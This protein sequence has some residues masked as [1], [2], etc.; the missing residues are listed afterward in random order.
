MM[1]KEFRQIIVLTLAAALCGQVLVAQDQDQYR[2]EYAAYDE[3][4]KIPDLSKRADAFIDFI[5]KFPQSTLIPYVDADYR[6]MLQEQFSQQKLDLTLQLTKKWLAIRPDDPL[7]LY[8][9]AYIYFQKGQQELAI[10][11]GERLYG[12]A[13]DDTKK[14]LAYILA[15]SAVQTGDTKRIIQYGDDACQ[16]FSPKKCYPV[17]VELMK[18]Y[19]SKQDFGTASAY[20]DKALAGL[21]EADPQDATTKDYVSKN[22][23]LAYAVKGN[24]DFQRENWNSAIR[25]YQKVL[26]T[27][28]NKALVGECYYK[29]GL[30]YWRLNK[31]EPEAMQAFARGHK[32]GT[33]EHAKQCFKHL[34]ELY[35]AG[36]NG[37]VAGM[38]EFI[39]RAVSSE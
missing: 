31:I 12:S 39:E 29:I 2:I 14:T 34:E 11:Q 35:R 13:D 28:S 8:F 32:R 5:G 21:A 17:N 26:R 24:N 37:S 22:T 15:F 7:G 9:T 3:A 18:H 4:K 38:D 6:R 33:G 36:H 27:T 23:T 19:S 25:N 16:Y 30:S 10:A 20:A 1:R